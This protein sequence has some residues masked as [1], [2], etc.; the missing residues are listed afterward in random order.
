MNILKC[1]LIFQWN[2]FW[3]VDAFKSKSFFKMKLEK[4]C[5]AFKSTSEYFDVLFLVLLTNL[6]KK[7]FFMGWCFQ[8]STPSLFLAFNIFNTAVL[9]KITT[10]AIAYSLCVTYFGFGTIP[11]LRQQMN[12]V[13]G[14]R[15]VSF[16][17]DV[18]YYLFWR[19]VVGW[20]RKGPKMRW[21]NIGMVSMHEWGRS[22]KIWMSTWWN[23]YVLLIF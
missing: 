5:F 17:A 11:I 3:C 20:V 9:L 18:H 16:F 22:Q 19:R 14:V 8:V 10:L 6:P 2:Y 1:W 13:G 23:R 21:R 7:L 12:W 15:K 4:K